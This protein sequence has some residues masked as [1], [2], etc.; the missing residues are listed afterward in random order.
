MPPKGCALSNLRDVFVS[1]VSPAARYD[2]N[3]RKPSEAVASDSA[4]ENSALA[5]DSHPTRDWA[6]RCSS[7][8]KSAAR[9][10]KVVRLQMLQNWQSKATACQKA[11]NTNKKQIKSQLTS[12]Q[13][14]GA[15]DHKIRPGAHERVF[16]RF[17]ACPGSASRQERFQKG[18]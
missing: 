14:H 16:C 1:L 2:L 4:D 9:I 15:R 18:H 6:I 3:V 8:V 10:P 11:K 17:A 5:F 13:N 12:R 7:S